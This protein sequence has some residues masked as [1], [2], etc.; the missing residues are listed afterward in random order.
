[1]ASNRGMSSR[2]IRA[3]H[4][5]QLT[6]KVDGFFDRVASREAAAMQCSSG[7]SDCCQ[8]GLTV[9][10]AEAES[11]ASGIEEMTLLQRDELRDNIVGR[12]KAQGSESAR[13]VALSSEG[14]CM[15][16]ATRPTVCRSHG[17]PIRL[18]NERSLPVV[19][20]CFRNFVERSPETIAADCVLDQTNLSATLLA[21]NSGSSD[22]FSI[23]ELLL[24]LIEQG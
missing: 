4:Y 21:I 15:V 3:A 19:T 7:C 24:D 20:S 14:R 8:Y 23:E 10:L 2:A 16:Y 5:R 17:V 11:L 9:T 22:R 18:L 1:M 6:D 13:C 12:S